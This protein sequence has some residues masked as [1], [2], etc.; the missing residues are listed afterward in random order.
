VFATSWLILSLLPF[1][2]FR[3]GNTGR[4]LYLPA[5][6]FSMLVADGVMQLD[7]LLEPRLS[8]AQRMAVLALVATAIAGRFALFAA[9]NVR[10]F[11]E[12]TEEYRRYITLFKQ[13][14][15]DLP[16]HSRVPIDPGSGGEQRY[17]FLNALAQWEYRDPTIELIPDRPNPR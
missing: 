11:A 12:R 2:F 7:R 13:T 4:Y 8:A 14:H 6:G 10:S 3:W 1:V 17:R 15:P 5:M 16:S 9:A